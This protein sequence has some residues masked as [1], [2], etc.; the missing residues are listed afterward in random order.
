[1][2]G[3]HELRAELD[4]R[5]ELCSCMSPC[6]VSWL[7]YLLT[8]HRQLE[9]RMSVTQA[10]LDALAS[11]LTDAEG[12][13]QSEIN[14]L[15]SDHPDL[16]LTGLQAAVQSVA[17]MVPDSGTGNGTATAPTRPLRRTPA[18]LRVR[19]SPP[20]AATAPTRPIPR[21]RR[22]PRPRT[23]RRPQL[24]ERLIVRRRALLRVGAAPR[25]TPTGLRTP[26]Y[27]YLVGVAEPFTKAS[28]TAGLI[29]Q[30]PRRTG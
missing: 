24:V 20:T 10:D 5:V 2:A 13:I 16:D 4:D 12:R 8:L 7:E 11:E 3:R 25:T 29:T 30:C 27:P 28:V 15:Q 21:C 18:T 14:Q 17:G 1:M 26:A 9:N 23:G 22:C 19:P 6:I